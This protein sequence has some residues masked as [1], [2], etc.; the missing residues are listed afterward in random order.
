[1]LWNCVPPTS[2]HVLFS[3][4]NTTTWLMAG[5]ELDEAQTPPEVGR[6]VGG[7]VV[8]GA[9]VAGA[10][11]AGAVV[12]GAVVAGAVVAVPPDPSSTSRTASR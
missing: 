10:V 12:A 2:D 11:V 6:V 3:F 1:M 7:A 8:G 4:E 9:V 5:C